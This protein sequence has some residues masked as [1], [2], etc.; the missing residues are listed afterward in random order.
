M[1]PPSHPVLNLPLDWI[2]AND[3]TPICCLVERWPTCV[4]RPLSPALPFPNCR[5]WCPAIVSSCPGGGVVWAK[6]GGPLSVWWLLSIHTRLSSSYLPSAMLCKLFRQQLYLQ[7]W[8]LLSSIILFHWCISTPF[9]LLFS[10]VWLINADRR[11]CAGVSACQM[12]DVLLS[13]VSVICNVFYEKYTLYKQTS[14]IH[15]DILGTPKFW[16]LTSLAFSVH[17]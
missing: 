9:C 11:T 1:A 4:V 13:N 14:R 17:T 8:L 15:K 5:Y 12:K 3:C 16:P 10:S 6:I 2:D 7:R